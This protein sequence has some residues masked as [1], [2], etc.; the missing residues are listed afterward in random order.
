MPLLHA[1]LQGVKRLQATPARRPRLPITSSVLR[2]LKLAWEW[3]ARAA[4]SDIRMLWAVACTCFFGFLRSGE[5]TVATLS[6]YDAR[7]HLSMADVA[8]DSRE[9]PTAVSLRI[10]A[11]RRIRS[12][13]ESPF[14]WDVWIGICAR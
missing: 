10:K 8:I 7:V 13:Q 14:T 3:S 2:L 4:T 5:A 12:T 1:V 9:A 11:L 6:G